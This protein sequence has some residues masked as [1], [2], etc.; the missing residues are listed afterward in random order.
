MQ[1]VL[2]AILSV[3]LALQTN[4]DKNVL[5][6]SDLVFGSKDGKANTAAGHRERTLF[7]F[8]SLLSKIPFH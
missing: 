3:E 1:F 4:C 2:L 5:T 8:K 7:N 6:A